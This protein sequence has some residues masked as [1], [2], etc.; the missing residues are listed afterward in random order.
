MSCHLGSHSRD[1]LIEELEEL[2]QLV[3][4]FDKKHLREILD[5]LHSLNRIRANNGFNELEDITQI[6]EQVQKHADRHDKKG[7]PRA[8]TYDAV[9]EDSMIIDGT[10]DGDR[11]SFGETVAPTKEDYKYFDLHE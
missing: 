3:E 6:F 8:A 4:D 2:G 1:S 9:N 10:S 5:F 7:K 11:A